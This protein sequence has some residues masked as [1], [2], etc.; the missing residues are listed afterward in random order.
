[1]KEPKCE[2]K[3]VKFHDGHEGAGVNADLWINGVNCGHIRDDGNGGCLDFE[4]NHDAKSKANVQLLND[5][6]DSLPEK[7]LN[8]GHGDIKDEQG[9]VR[10]D[11]TDLEDYVNELLYAY[12]RAK[13][14]KKMEKQMVNSILF[15]IPNGDS[16]RMI[17]Y[18]VPLSVLAVSHKPFLIKKVMEIQVNECKN[19]VV[20]L[21]TNLQTLGINI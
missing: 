19:G 5:Y 9:N 8:F 6:I 18:K 16:Y 3:N 12:E 11:K 4:F 13:T 1:M 17:Q 15:G 21:N 14:K 20:I 2:V 10:M 7:P